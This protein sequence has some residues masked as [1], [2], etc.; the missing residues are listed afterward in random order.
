MPQANRSSNDHEIDEIPP[1]TR[2]QLRPAVPELHVPPPK[3]EVVRPSSFP[4]RF[5]SGIPLAVDPSGWRTHVTP[6]AVAVALEVRAARVERRR[7]EAQT[8]W[9][10]AGI[11][12]LAFALVAAIV[13][14]AALR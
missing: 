12:A 2:S 8:R 9:I 10:V 11:W 13:I 7:L 5:P 6:G 1:T 4:S 3:A 14:A